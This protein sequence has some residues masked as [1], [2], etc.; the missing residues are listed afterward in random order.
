VASQWRARRIIQQLAPA[1]AVDEAEEL[2]QL[3]VAHLRHPKI[4]Y[5]D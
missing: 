1:V 4:D 3:G 2:A 5:Q